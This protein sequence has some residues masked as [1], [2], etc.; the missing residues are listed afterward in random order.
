MKANPEGAGVY[1]DGVEPDSPAA[2]VALKK[3][4]VITAVDGKPV[5]VVPDLAGAL[6]G[7]NA[8]DTV[9]LTIKRGDQTLSIPAPLI[10]TQDGRVIIG[11]VPNPSPPDW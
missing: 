5:N 11:F 3:G 4:D 9:T 8:G 2:K 7:K 6:K 1:V 10:S